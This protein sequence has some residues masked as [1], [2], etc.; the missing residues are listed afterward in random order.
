ME[1]I[2][3][4]EVQKTLEDRRRAFLYLVASTRKERRGNSQEAILG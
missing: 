4:E 3:E 2:F 1:G